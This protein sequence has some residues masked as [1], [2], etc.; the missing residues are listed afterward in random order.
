MVS[1]R[2]FNILP[3]PSTDSE[4]LQP[5][6]P[7]PPVLSLLPLLL[8][9]KKLLKLRQPGLNGKLPGTLL[10]LPLPP[11]RR[12]LR[13]LLRLLLR[14]ERSVRLRKRRLFSL[15]LFPSHMLLVVLVCLLV[16]QLTLLPTLTLL[17]PL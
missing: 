12:L 3:T 4:C 9:L 13:R 5:I 7:L 17:S 1:F 2:L 11:L 16:F 8:L 15:L 6:F 10:L 14:R